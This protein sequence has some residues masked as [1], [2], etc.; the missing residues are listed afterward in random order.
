MLPAFS[1]VPSIYGGRR[2]V[3]S[4]AIGSARFTEELY[5]KSKNQVL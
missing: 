4:V 5:L 2:L 1:Q 3:C